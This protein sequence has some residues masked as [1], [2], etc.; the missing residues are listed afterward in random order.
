MW[1]RTSIPLG[2][3]IECLP[4]FSLIHIKNTG[5]A[6]G[7]FQGRNWLFI[8]IGI[9]LIGIIVV[10]G[11][12]FWKSDRLTSMVF[13]LVLGGAL[14]NMTDRIV[15]GKVTDFLD[16]FIGSYHWPAFNVSDSAITVGAIL[17]ILRGVLNKSVPH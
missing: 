9:I 2:S 15:Y 3:E 7:L 16:F 12:N 11:I 13:A 14:G 1:V 17:M 8:I 6:F 10:A 5:M 4:F